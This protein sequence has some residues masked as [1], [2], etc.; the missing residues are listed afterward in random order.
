MSNPEQFQFER[1]PNETKVA[2]KEAKK[3]FLETVERIAKSGIAQSKGTY[4][5]TLT[6]KKES[7]QDSDMYMHVQWWP[8]ESAEVKITTT[9]GNIEMEKTYLLV[10]GSDL[11]H[12]VRETDMKEA[13]KNYKDDMNKEEFE[14]HMKQSEASFKSEQIIDKEREEAGLNLVTEAELLN[15]IAEIEESEKQNENNWQHKAA[16]DWA[17]K[18]PKA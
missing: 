15:V 8:N 13:Q 2:S 10:M 6:L 7:G 11:Q 17:R 16:L 1:D 4:F 3:H 12:F 14:M 9:S 18:M 5:N